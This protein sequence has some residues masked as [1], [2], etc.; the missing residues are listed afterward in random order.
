[1][2]QSTF[3]CEVGKKIE[4]KRKGEMKKKGAE[5]KKLKTKQT[6]HDDPL[7][8]YYSIKVIIMS[9]ICHAT[10]LKPFRVP[11]GELGATWNMF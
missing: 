1:M 11:S 7:V 9:I 10:D 3:K 4:M 6:S 8:F 2:T 5:L